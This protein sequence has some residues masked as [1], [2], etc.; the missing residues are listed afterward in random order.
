MKYIAKIR[1]EFEKI[2]KVEAKTEEEARKMFNGNEV[3]DIEETAIS[4]CEIIG[5][6]TEVE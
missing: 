6:I 2:Q 5:E 1:G 3:D 4:V